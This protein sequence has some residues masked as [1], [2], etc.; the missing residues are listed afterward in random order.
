[1]GI[2]VLASLGES[3]AALS[4]PIWI[5]PL[6]KKD[7]G[8]RKGWGG[9]GH[10]GLFS[11]TSPWRVIFLKLELVPPLPAKKWVFDAQLEVP[12]GREDR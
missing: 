2:S 4:N 7:E 5:Y 10:L 6:S 9:V 11:C 8:E 12:F 1:M 3:V